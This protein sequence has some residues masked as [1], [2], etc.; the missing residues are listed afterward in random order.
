MDFCL[1]G[2]VFPIRMNGKKRNCPSAK[3]LALGRQRLHL[4]G[5]WAHRQAGESLR[6][7]LMR[8]GASTMKT[9]ATVASRS[10]KLNFDRGDRKMNGGLWREEA[11][12]GWLWG[13]PFKFYKAHRF[14]AYTAWESTNFPTKVE[15]RICLLL[16]VWLGAAW[17]EQNESWFFSDLTLWQFESPHSS[18][19]ENAKPTCFWEGPDENRYKVS[20]RFRVRAE[21]T[22]FPAFWSLNEVSTTTYGFTANVFLGAIFGIFWFFPFISYGSFLVFLSTF[23]PLRGQKVTFFRQSLSNFGFLYTNA[24]GRVSRTILLFNLSRFWIVWPQRPINCFFGGAKN[25]N[26]S[27]SKD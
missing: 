18:W 10:V 17:K 20:T 19:S 16:T 14:M 27:G 22:S 23:W 25:W 5:I 12:L 2:C 24:S 9:E 7:A 13:P 21:T 26:L 15:K 3:H 1:R 11:A 4:S 6:N 8:F